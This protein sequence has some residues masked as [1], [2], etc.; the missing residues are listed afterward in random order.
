MST[1]TLKREDLLGATSRIPVGEL[2]IDGQTK[3]DYIWQDVRYGL[4]RV[5]YDTDTKL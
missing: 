1:S 5:T 2:L 3:N 4:L